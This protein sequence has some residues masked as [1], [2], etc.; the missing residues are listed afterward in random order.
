[1][2]KISI[3]ILGLFFLTAA[4]AQNSS[5][6]KDKYK[7]K[8]NDH[9][10]IQFT[11]DTWSGK[12]DSI[13]TKGIG[14]GANIY[15]MIN[16]PF[17]TNKNLSVAFGAGFGTSS[18]YLSKTSASITGNTPLLVFK[19]LDTLQ[20]FKKYKVATAYLEI[21]LELRYTKNPDNADKSLKFAIGAKVGTLL[22]A[23]TKGKTLQD[24]NGATLN[25]YTEKLKKKSYFNSTRIAL[26]AR[27]GY[28]H[29]SLYAQYQVT[30]V[31]KDAVSAPIKPLSIG[32]TI[33]GL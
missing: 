30:S 3:A 18:I 27:V 4:F 2:K 23:F 7:G 31:F 8:A 5:V 16:K 12:P 10:M 28:G 25:E 15:F 26:T 13:K 21:P 29:F 9:F 33:S 14:R 22:S 32:F 11:G 19:N 24:K 20:R 6:P 17:K 1:M